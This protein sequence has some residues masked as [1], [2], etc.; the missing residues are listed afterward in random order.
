MATR[1]IE[2]KSATIKILTGFIPHI[3]KYA[4]GVLKVGDLPKKVTITDP[5]TD[6]SFDVELI[7]V[8]PFKTTIPN[9]FSLL[10][11]GV[12]AETCHHDI[13]FRS[14]ATKVDQ[15]AFYLYRYVKNNQ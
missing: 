4:P 15:L 14:N 8:V 7:E 9:I 3:G 12:E 1:K 5:E 11:E 10:S 6:E 13:L 2:V